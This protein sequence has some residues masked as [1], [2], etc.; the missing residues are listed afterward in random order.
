MKYQPQPI[1][2]SNIQLPG[3]LD[4]LMEQLAEN[5]HNVWAVQR[6]AQGW[7]YGPSRDDAGKKHPCLVPYHQLPESEKDYDRK[8]ASETLKAILKLGYRIS[9]PA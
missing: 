5:T 6:M 3:S 7:T 2:T 1:D 9:E 4:Q 8:T